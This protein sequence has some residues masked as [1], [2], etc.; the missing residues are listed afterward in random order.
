VSLIDSKP[1]PQGHP[2]EADDLPDGSH[3]LYNLYN[4]LSAKSDAVLVNNCTDHS[5]N[6]MVLVR[7]ISFNFEYPDAHWKSIEWSALGN[8]C[9]ISFPVLYIIPTGI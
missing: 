1:P 7:H 4:E 6:L 2:E 8:Y 9:G 5:R 3:D